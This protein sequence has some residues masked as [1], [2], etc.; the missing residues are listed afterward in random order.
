MVSHSENSNKTFFEKDRDD[1][2]Q[3]SYYN[4]FYI[5][6]PTNMTTIVDKYNM[7]LEHFIIPISK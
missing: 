6:K 7:L 1:A 2:Y 5:F 3:Q 4:Y